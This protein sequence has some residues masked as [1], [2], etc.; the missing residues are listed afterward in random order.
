MRAIVVLALLAGLASGPRAGDRE[1]QRP[2]TQQRWQPDVGAARR[3]AERRPG[4]VSFAIIAG[5]GRTRGF[6]KARTAPAASTI[7]AM[8]LAAYL[9]SAHDRPLRADERALLEPM[10]RSSDN[11][12]GVQVAAMLGGEPLERLARAARM[13]DFE[14]VWEPGWLGG[15]SQISARD[16][17]RFFL[18]YPRHLPKR[19]RR[20][21]R[22]LLGSIVEW[23]RWGIGEVRPPHW[24]LYFK[25]G[26]GIEDDGLGTVNHQV[27]FLERGKCRV[28]LA[29]LTEHNPSTEDGAETL[30]GVAHRLLR[31]IERAP[32]GERPKQGLGRGLDL[33]KERRNPLDLLTPWPGA[34]LGQGR[35]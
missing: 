17:A 20:F 34:E 32:C 35:P 2:A 12:A 28:A 25:G 19:H 15:Q 33:G 27:A 8:L 21:A 26:W 24:R 9:R 3:Y 5:G 22:R 16:Q 1:R 29:I 13:R 11:A 18:R 10:I 31:G 4:D 30:R 6:Q 23:Q 7:K 14:W